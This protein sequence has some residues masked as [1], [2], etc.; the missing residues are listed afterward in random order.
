M[1]MS[2]SRKLRVPAAASLAVL[3]T[4]V[5]R[6]FAILNAT[7]V[8]FA[9]LIAILV[10]AAWWGITEAVVASVIATIC[11]NY[12][13]LPPVGT[14]AIADPENWVAL[15]AFLVSS[16][17]ASD[18]SNRAR[19]RTAEANARKMEME[20]L[21]ALS[22]AILAMESNQPIGDRIASELA[23]ICEIPA[24]A[25]YDRTSDLVHRSGLGELPEVEA[26]LRQIAQTGSPSKDDRTGTIF[27]P[28]NLGGNSIG[29][30]A[31]RGAELSNT[32]LHA[33][34]N[35]IAISLENARSREIVT[36]AQAAQ[37]SEEFKSTLLD[38]LAHEFKTPLTSIKAATTALLASNVSDAAQQQ[39]LL[40]VVDQEAERLSRLVTEAT[41]V[42]RI[43]AGK[44]HLNR[45]WHSVD[46][47]IQTVLAQMEPQ[48]D[49]R[50]LDVS[51]APNLGTV[52]VDADLIQLAL[53]QLIDNA[54]K[55]SPRKS[56]IQ[57]SSQLAQGKVVI[58]VRNQ[59]EP[60]S[61]AERVRIFD[62]FYRGRN[63][64]RQVA[65]TGMGLP[66]A[67]SI[68]VAHGGDVQLLRSSESGTEFVVSIPVGV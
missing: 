4:L 65:G 13:F 24:V 36:R 59:G 23:R 33:L 56:V 32:A 42:A 48:C 43:E 19:R 64:R 46:I 5:F 2:L 28:I 6:M 27:A 41:R 11:F 55:Y 45:E 22:R 62:K 63:V 57:I 51:I 26:R 3:I 30:I 29:S 16:L 61:E 7:T 49:G 9:Y 12:F 38:G 25:I 35:L 21:Y 34:L 54:L 60:L 66:V 53:R 40:T 31:I 50:R 39:E 37:E 58:A 47:L 68:L 20:R 15:F 10:V 1:E 17:I 52:L 18:L 67:R 14:W 44:I 8:G